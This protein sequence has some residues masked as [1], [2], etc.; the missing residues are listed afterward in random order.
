MLPQ[1]TQAPGVPSKISSQYRASHIIL[2]YLEAFTPK[3]A[4]NPRKT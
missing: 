3:Y 2:D 1:G 4:H